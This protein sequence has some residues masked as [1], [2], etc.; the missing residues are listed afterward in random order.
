MTELWGQWLSAGLG[1]D[2]FWRIV[3]REAVLILDGERKRRV[4]EHDDARARNYEMA[5]LTSYAF[6]SPNKMPNYKPSRLER[7][8]SSDEA[9]QAQVRAHFIA[10]AMASESKRG[11]DAKCSQ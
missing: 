2:L 1:A 8:V 3:P 6:H 11:R 9:A 4:R 5:T 10:L 7:E